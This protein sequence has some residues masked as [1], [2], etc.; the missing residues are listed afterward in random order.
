MLHNTSGL[1]IKNH[2]QITVWIYTFTTNFKVL[3]SGKLQT[4]S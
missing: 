4:V 3:D 2:I 1:E